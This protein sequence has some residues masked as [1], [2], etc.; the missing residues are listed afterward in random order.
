MPIEFL[1]E[2]TCSDR[3]AGLLEIG[4]HQYWEEAM[5]YPAVLFY[6][7]NIRDSGRQTRAVRAFWTPCIWYICLQSVYV[8]PTPWDIG[9]FWCARWRYPC[10][11]GYYHLMTESGKNLLVCPWSKAQVNENIPWS[12]IQGIP[13]NREHLSTG[14]I[15]LYSFITFILR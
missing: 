15:K 5:L 10:V 3:L 6:S 1:Q 2:T 9:A 8:F 7:I 13:L 14:R 12:H 4:E 11:D